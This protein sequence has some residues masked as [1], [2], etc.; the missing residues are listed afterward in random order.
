M[1]A[2]KRWNRSSWI[3]VEFNLLYR[4]HM[5]VP[6]PIDDRRRARSTAKTFLRDN[7]A[8]VIDRGHRVADGPVLA[9]PG[10]TDRPVQHPRL[11]HRPAGRRTAPRS[12]SGR[13][14]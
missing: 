3:A 1:A 4:W 7:N 12:R 10:G 2:N 9:V 11:P 6:D 5:L 13:S 8:L 14:R